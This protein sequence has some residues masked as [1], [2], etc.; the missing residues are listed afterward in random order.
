MPNPANRHP[1]T[2]ALPLDDARYRVT[3]RYTPGVGYGAR[4]E[5]WAGTG[6]RGIGVYAGGR[7]AAESLGALVR[8]HRHLSDLIE[9]RYLADGLNAID[10]GCPA[11]GYSHP[12]VLDVDGGLIGCAACGANTRTG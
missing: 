11:C 2:Q 7:S 6:W 9:A 8:G 12:K 3:I 4:V 1:I 5:A 10:D